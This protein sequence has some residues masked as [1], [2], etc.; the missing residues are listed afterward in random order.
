MD[1]S[2]GPLKALLESTSS[3]AGTP[4]TCPLMALWE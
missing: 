4:P 3:G 1:P 2:A